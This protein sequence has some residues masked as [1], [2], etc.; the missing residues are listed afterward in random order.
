MAKQYY[1]V[2]DFEATCWPEAN[3]RSDEEIIEF[4]CIRMEYSTRR[5]LDEFQTFVRPT[6]YPR[7]SQYCTRLTSITQQDVDTAPAFPEALA[8]FVAW[9]REPAQCT[10]CSWGAFDRYLL[11]QACAFHRLPYPF[12]D[13]YINIKPA[14]SD[15]FVGRGVN[16]E[17]ALEIAEL[18]APLNRHRAIDDARNAAALWQEVLRAGG[19]YSAR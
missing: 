11:R 1:I 12:D 4:G 17:R 16:M 13:E 3:R 9:L 14:F 5:I 18:P 8:N 7:L 15:A 10:L 6:R 2:L 19:A